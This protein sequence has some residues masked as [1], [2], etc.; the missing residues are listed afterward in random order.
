MRS[1]VLRL[2]GGVVQEG[3]VVGCL[4]LDGGVFIRGIEIALVEQDSLA[5]ARTRFARTSG[6]GLGILT[7]HV[8]LD[9]FHFQGLARF[10]C[11][12]P[13]VSDDGDTGQQALGGTAEGTLL[14]NDIAFHN[15][16]IAHTWHGLDFI[17]V[18]TGYLAAVGRAFFKHGIEHA[19]HFHID[20]KQWLTANDP[21]DI[22]ILSRCTDD[23]EGGRIFQ[24]HDARFGHR[25]CCR[26]TGHIAVGECEPGCRVGNDT[27]S[28]ATGTGGY[29]PAGSG[30]GNEHLLAGS[31]GLAHGYE[32]PGRGKTA[33]G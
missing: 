20:A 9:P 30:R 25:L 7:S 28:R 8:G 14:I 31:A 22:H 3:I 24:G 13:P 4:H 6:K 21:V 23:A 26:L 32:I 16:S 18:G 12:P 10:L 5:L 11:L 29:P 17:Q 33:T 27:V 19:G 2:H 1:R 15:E